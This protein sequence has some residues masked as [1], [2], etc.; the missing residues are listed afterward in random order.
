MRTYQF[1]YEIE[2]SCEEET[3]T[4]DY[5]GQWLIKIKIT[6]YL[7]IARY[8][9]VSYLAEGI[10]Q[11]VEVFLRLGEGIKLVLGPFNRAL[12][13]LNHLSHYLAFH[14]NR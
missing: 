4:S 8:V 2:N 10:K 6:Q 13:F 7:Q 3:N 11:R 9:S 5:L 12:D 14:N 1:P